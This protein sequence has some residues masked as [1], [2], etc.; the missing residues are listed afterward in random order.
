MKTNK[1]HIQRLVGTAILAA[2]VI[3]L[4]TFLVIP[5]GP[6]TVTLTL[7][8][9]MLGAILFGPSAGAFLG[10]VFGITVSVQVVT[11]A[12]GIFSYMMFEQ[13]PVLT[14][15]ICLLKGIV[16]GLV[17]GL[18]YKL[19]SKKE[20]KAIGTVLSAVACPICNT[21]IFAIAL[22]VFYN[23]LTLNFATENTSYTNVYLFILFGMIGLNFVV[24]FVINVL[25]IPVILRIIHAVKTKA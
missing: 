17:S 4:Q 12:A 25:L 13:N 21:G 16:A 10:G 18:I 11:G 15:F 22:M 24:E 3:V 20:K 1:E 14:I 23:S 7:V 9:I 8:P 2:I 6:F 5:L 19:F